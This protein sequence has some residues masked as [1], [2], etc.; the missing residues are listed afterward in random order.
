M[1]TVDIWTPPSSDIDVLQPKSVR[2]GFSKRRKETR[3]RFWHANVDSRS[4]EMVTRVDQPHLDHDVC[5]LAVNTKRLEVVTASSDGGLHF[6]TPKLR[7]RNGIPVKDQT[8]SQLTTWT[9]SRILDIEPMFAADEYK[10]ISAT[11][12]YS[13]DGSVVAASWSQASEDLRITH[14]IETFDGTIALSQPNLLSPGVAKLGFLRQNLLC[15][16]RDAVLVFDT[17][18]LETLLTVS[19]DP[20]SVIGPE[21]RLLAT[22]PRDG[23]FAL[24]LSTSDSKELGVWPKDSLI[25]VFNI[26]DLSSDPIYQSQVQQKITNLLARPQGP[27]YVIVDSDARV[28]TLMPQGSLALARG[29]PGPDAYAASAETEEVRRGLDSIFGPAGKTLDRSEQVQSSVMEASTSEPSTSQGTIESV[30][31]SMSG[32]PVS[33]RNIFDKIAGLFVRK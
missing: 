9:C 4:W 32:Q 8:G 7:V 18:L 19:L 33:I 16:S 31:V 17:V 11:L 12:A 28:S 20:L 13:E 22:N 5:D 10:H 6:W 24:A 21:S 27:G 29:L 14:L 25:A 26:Y 15:L 3:L 1:V 23:T 30:F 2:N